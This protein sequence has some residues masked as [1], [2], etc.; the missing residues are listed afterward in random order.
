MRRKCN[1]SEPIATLNVELHKDAGFKGRVIDSNG[2]AV[3]GASVAYRSER[4]QSAAPEI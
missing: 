3:E 2:R 1:R 4:K